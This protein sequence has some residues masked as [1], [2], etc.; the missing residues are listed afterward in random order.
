MQPLVPGSDLV[1]FKEKK[2]NR[3]TRTCITRINLKNMFQIFV[4]IDVIMSI[5]NYLYKICGKYVF[6]AFLMRA[7]IWAVSPLFF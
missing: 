1:L 2:Y 4:V 6:L 5:N 7:K 3:N